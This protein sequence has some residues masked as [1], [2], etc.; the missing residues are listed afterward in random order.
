LNATVQANPETAVAVF[1]IA[2][3]RCTRTSSSTTNYL[4]IWDSKL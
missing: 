2:H 3:L 1:L 4:S